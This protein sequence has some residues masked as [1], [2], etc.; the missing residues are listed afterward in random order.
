MPSDA[1]ILALAKDLGFVALHRATDV[2]RDNDEIVRAAVKTNGDALQFASERLRDDGTIVFPAVESLGEALTHASQRLRDSESVVRVAVG[3]SSLAL[4]FASERLRDDEKIVR[5]AL[6]SGRHNFAAGIALRFGSERLRDDEVFVRRVVDRDARALEFASDRLRDD[7]ETV[8]GAVESNGSALKYASERLQ[9]DKSIVRTALVVGGYHVIEYASLRLRD[10]E[11][12][13]REAVKRGGWRTLELASERL[14]DDENIIQTALEGNDH[15]CNPEDVLW[16]ASERL[17]D[18][19]YLDSAKGQEPLSLEL[20]SERLKDDEATVREAMQRSVFQI[21]YAS[22]RLRDNDNFALA[23]M[24]SFQADASKIMSCVSP[25]LQAEPSFLLKFLE[26]QGIHNRHDATN[27]LLANLLK[28]TAKELV[29]ARS[30]LNREVIDVDSGETTYEPAPK[31]ARTERA[32]PLPRSGLALAAEAT[33]S[34]KEIKTE[35]TTQRDAERRRADDLAERNECCVCMEADAAVCFLPC[36]H[37]ATCEACAAPLES[38]TTCR[39][40]IQRRITVFR[41]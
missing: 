18:I 38:C 9:D 13:I 19:Y 41:N 16:Y 7:E 5:A 17:R 30:Q 12:L 26:I 39:E 28:D 37:L 21:R 15:T 35:L 4:K 24:K 2:Q 25:R 36:R 32:E 34:A 3:N 8:R 6:A 27:S 40:P 33:T 29:E 23:A 31:R 10:D 20:A 11:E 1:E 22:E 14:R